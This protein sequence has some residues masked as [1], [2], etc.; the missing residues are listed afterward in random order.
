M[1]AQAKSGALSILTAL[2][3]AIAPA[4]AKAL[5]ERR[6]RS[7]SS[8]GEQEMCR[9]HSHLTGTLISARNV[10]EYTEVQMLV[11]QPLTLELLNGGKLTLPPYTVC[12]LRQD[13]PGALSVSERHPTGEQEGADLSKVASPSTSGPITQA[14]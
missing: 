2:A 12:L 10:G 14:R 8:K 7:P 9:N 3:A 1:E 13:H 5:I 11:E 4:V 6:R